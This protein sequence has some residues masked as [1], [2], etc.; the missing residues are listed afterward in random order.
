MAH[1]NVHGVCKLCLKAAKLCKS[2]YLSRVLHTL[3]RMEGAHPIVMTPRLIKSTPCQMW[4]HLLCEACEG[5]LNDRGEKPLL[6]LFNG[7]SDNFPLLNRMNLALPVRVES[8]VITYSGKAMGIDTG[9]LAYYALSVL[10]KGSV[11]KWTTLKG[12]RSS[13]DLGKY[14]EPA[15]RYL[16]GDAGFPEGLYVIVTACIDRGSQGMTFAPSKVSESLYPMYSLLVRG[17]WFHVIAT[18]D[19]PLGMSELCCARSAKGVLFKADCTEPFLQAGRHIHR[20]ATVSAD[21]R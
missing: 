10:W 15:R 7:A 13:I 17:I 3:S 8:T 9:A 1:K 12:Q 6:A 18:D 16:H 2:H 21:L 14:Q 4:A 5:R 11:H 20:T 19:S